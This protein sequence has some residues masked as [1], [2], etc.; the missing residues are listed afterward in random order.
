ME[1]SLAA[2]LHCLLPM[3]SSIPCPSTTGIFDSCLRTSFWPPIAAFSG[4]R[5]GSIHRSFVLHR[6]GEIRPRRCRSLTRACA[7]EPGAL[8]TPN[9]PTNMSELEGLVEE[10]QQLPFTETGDDAS[11]GYAPDGCYGVGHILLGIDIGG[12]TIKAA[13]V[14]TKTGA[15]LRPRHVID[16]PQPATPKAVAL[17]LKQQLEH[18]NWKGGVGVGIPAVVRGGIVCTA[19][20]IDQSWIGTNVDEL[21]HDVTGVKMA[22]VN[23]ADAA[24]YAEMAFGAGS[25]LEKRKGIVI[26][27][28]FGTGIG[29]AMFVDGILVPN[30]ELGHVELDGVEAEKAA[31]GVLVKLKSWSWEEWA[32]KVGWYLSYLERLMWPTLF[33]V[34]GGVSNAHEEWLSKVK[35]PNKTPVVVATFRNDAGITGAALAALA[36]AAFEAT[37]RP[38]R[39]DDYL[40]A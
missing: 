19:A 5:S 3:G 9:A 7:P 21:F 6:L 36:C 8:A 10:M 32:K 14:D 12:T 20:N 4:S 17:V 23:D 31:A 40:D 24:G 13:P 11:S 15:L 18:F 34:G 39:V 33:I 16:T 29:T 25:G 35:L 27:C 37:S 26:M 1:C 38:Q 22:V 30:L 2:S 28:T